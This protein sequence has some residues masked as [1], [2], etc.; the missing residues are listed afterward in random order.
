MMETCVV[1][2]TSLNER[3]DVGRAEREVGEVSDPFCL[4]CHHFDADNEFDNVDNHIYGADIIIVMMKILQHHSAHDKSLAWR[5]S[6]SASAG[7]LRRPPVTL[8]VTTNLDLNIVSVNRQKCS[9]H[10]SH[11]VPTKCLVD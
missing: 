10:H 3:E 8:P 5:L 2:A 6:L 1:L 11:H 9:H 7:V 4:Q